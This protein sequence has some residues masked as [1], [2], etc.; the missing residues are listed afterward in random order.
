MA[1]ASPPDG[2]AAAATATDEAAEDE[3]ALD[4]AFGPP[5]EDG[6]SGDAAEERPAKRRKGSGKGSAAP[7]G[8]VCPTSKYCVLFAV[9]MCHGDA[10]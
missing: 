8:R 10:G 7:T 3:L 5:G 9:L 1:P 4:D 2:V 6:G